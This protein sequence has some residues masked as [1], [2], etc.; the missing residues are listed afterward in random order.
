NYIGTDIDGKALVLD[1][2][3]SGNQFVGN[4][5]EGVLIDSGADHNLVG[6]TEAG[7]GNVISGNGTSGGSI[8]RNAF[9]NARQGTRIG[10][11]S[12]GRG[13]L[14]N[15]LA[16]VLLSAAARSNTIGGTV[17]GAGNVISGG[18]VGVSMIGVGTTNN[19]VQ[20]NLIG[21]DATGANALGNR[22]FG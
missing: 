2:D 15:G 20:G 10:P 7:A 18:A 5:N 22:A 13:R 8:A 12:D 17:K 16:G 21:T 1:R 3:P 19:L 11:T 6:G 14:A 4:F 9:G